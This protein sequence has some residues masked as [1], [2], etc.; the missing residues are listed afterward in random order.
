MAEQIFINSIRASC[1]LLH[2]VAID[3]GGSLQV[4][5][6]CSDIDYEKIEESLTEIVANVKIIREGGARYH[7]TYI[8]VCRLKFT[9]RTASDDGSAGVTRQTLGGS[10]SCASDRAELMRRRP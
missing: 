1:N 9:V 6:Q 5:A 7:K 2:D 4:L 10:S 8:Q 3:K